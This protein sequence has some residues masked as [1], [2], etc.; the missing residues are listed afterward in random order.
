MRFRST[1]VGHDVLEDY[2]RRAHT[3]PDSVIFL[4]WAVWLIPDFE[5]YRRVIFIFTFEKVRHR[6]QARIAVWKRKS[7]GDEGT[8]SQNREETDHLVSVLKCRALCRGV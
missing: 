6:I 3:E 5:M 1:F 8:G 7:I 4:S 2:G